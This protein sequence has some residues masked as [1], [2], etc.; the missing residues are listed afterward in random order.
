MEAV[1]KTGRGRLFLH[2]LIEVAVILVLLSAVFRIVSSLNR[3][4]SITLNKSFT[5]TLNGQT[6]PGDTLSGT[7]FSEHLLRGDIVTYRTTLPSTIPKHSTLCVLTYL[8]C[9]DIFMDGEKLYSCG[10]E[11]YQS[12]RM[13]GSGWHFIPLPENSAGHN[14]TVVITCGDRAA[15]TSL[16]PVIIVDSEYVFTNFASD[17]MMEFVTGVFLTILGLLVLVFMLILLVREKSY[18]TWDLM[19]IGVF[20]ILIGTWILCN[21]K[22]IELVTEQYALFTNLEYDTLYLAI[23]PF[24]VMFYLQVEDDA[25]RWKKILMRI[26]ILAVGLFFAVALVLQLTH[27][28]FIS[29][30]LP[31]FHFLLVASAM[32]FLICG[33]HG[34]AVISDAGKLI[35]AGTICFIT[36]AVADLLIFVIQKY[37]LITNDSFTYSLMPYGALLMVMF[38]IFSYLISFSDATVVLSENRALEKAAYL[39][40]LTSL[41]NRAYAE[42]L[43]RNY[44]D[45]DKPF[46]IVSLDING[47]KNINDN[48]GHAYGDKLLKTF[49]DILRECFDD[50]QIFLIRMGGDEFMIFSE[51]Q[52]ADKIEKGLVQMNRE[53][54]KASDRFPIP[55]R[56]SY[57]TAHSIELYD[58]ENSELSKAERV[59]SLADSRMYQMKH[60]DGAIRR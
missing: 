22:A 35:Y 28:I 18:S 41:N 46:L 48:F 10:W 32:T 52:D 27:L 44:S 6:L 42:K 20:S 57:G 49:A 11:E 1:K 5:I 16:D 37:I 23:V 36:S 4:P 53:C 17:H 59:Y 40:P 31:V 34:K 50:A 7:K 60:P 38:L 43:F 56:A 21:S 2:V 58:Q 29:T 47:L 24:S 12:D 25:S 9:V 19:C 33:S 54:Q 45:S 30:V 39:D 3:A 55:V 14:V 13:V 51:E 26:Q 15:F 8:S